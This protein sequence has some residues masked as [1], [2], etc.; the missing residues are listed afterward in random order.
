VR[1]RLRP[2]TPW[3]AFVAGAVLAYLMSGA[4]NLGRLQQQV[5]AAEQKTARQDSAMTQIAE[6]FCQARVDLDFYHLMVLRDWRNES[7]KAVTQR[8]AGAELD[9]CEW[10]WS[11][12]NQPRPW[13]R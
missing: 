8:Y 5:D 11:T 7:E 9:L 3:L 13:W 12:P 10:Y 1:E 2:W 4:G 6:N